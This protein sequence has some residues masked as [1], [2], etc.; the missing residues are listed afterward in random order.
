VRVL[1]PSL[2]QFGISNRLSDPYLAIYDQNG[3]QFAANDNW[4]D[5]QQPEITSYHLAPG[6]R[7]EPALYV[8]LAGGNYTAVVTSSDGTMGV[9]LIET[10]NL[11]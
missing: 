6:N 8:S 9:A 7:L 1:G 2:A 5:G 4:E 3:T 10:Y 11:P